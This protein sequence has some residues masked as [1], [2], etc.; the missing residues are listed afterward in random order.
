M[1]LS[2]ISVGLANAEDMSLAAINEAKK[3]KKLYLE[4]YT[5]KGASLQALQKLLK[6]KIIPLKRSAMEDDSEKLVLEAKKNSVGILI[7][8]HA[9]AATTH[10]GLLQECRER[11]VKYTVI[12]GS[13]ILTAVSVTGLT[14]Y[15]F[16][17]TTSIPFLN[18]HV[19]EPYNA[20]KLNKSVG[21]HT[22]FL[23]DL[24][25]GTYMS[26]QQA[27]DYLYRVET[28]SKDGLIT[29]NT[30]AVICA[31]LGS[32]K[33]TIMSGNL[34]DLRTKKLSVY[35]QVLIIPGKMQFYEEDYLKGFETHSN[36]RS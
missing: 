11:K 29:D 27:I 23:L 20:Y 6:K 3:C 34:K 30:Y 18:E 10:V 5:N 17:K 31:G 32:K 8:G 26:A 4:T 35:P 12:H 21:L 24:K 15:T 36:I 25:D 1:T 2:L 22:L 9:L 33:E 13:S 28:E 19:K 14:L 7:Y 16:G